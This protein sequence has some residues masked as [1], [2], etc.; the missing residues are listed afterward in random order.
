MTLAEQVQQL[1]D[2][3][4]IQQMLSAY[5]RY[6]DNH[7]I[8][9]MAALFVEDC[10]ANYVP[11][12]EEYVIRGRDV[13]QGFLVTHQ[14]NV[15]SGSHYITNTEFIFHAAD[16]VTVYAYMYSWQRF[17]GYPVTADCHRLG[18]YELLLVRKD[19]AWRIAEL[20][21]LS[22]GEYGGARIGEQFNRPWPPEFEKLAESHTV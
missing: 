15:I 10:V 9:A 21:L 6:A 18:R 16:T 20:R 5:C 13:L 8:D 4:D 19:D 17:K 14:D 7:E 12:M 11:T 22:S 1:Q 3:A 2:R